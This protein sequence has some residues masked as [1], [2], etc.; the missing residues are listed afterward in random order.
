MAKSKGRRAVWSER[1]SQ[2]QLRVARFDGDAVMPLYHAAEIARKDAAIAELVGALYACLPHLPVHKYYGAR[3]TISK[4]DKA[5][6]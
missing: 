6:L 2:E 4:Y 1:P 5:E 3:D